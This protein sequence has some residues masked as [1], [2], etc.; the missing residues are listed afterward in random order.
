M[1]M[2]RTPLLFLALAASATSGS[3]PAAAGQAARALPTTVTA[4]FVRV[5][6]AG[7]ETKRAANRQTTAQTKKSKTAGVNSNSKSKKKGKAPA[8]KRSFHGKASWYGG[9]RFN[10][11]KTASGD[12]FSGKQ[13]SA[14]H[15]TL[16]L[17]TEVRVTN[18]ENDRSTVLE[19]NDR[20]PPKSKHV[21]DLSRAAAKKLDFVEDGSVLVRV[22]VLGNPP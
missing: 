3:A 7:P 21:I 16:P 17:G 11:R 22:D 13:L 10:G 15:P 8:A 5:V 4:D 20:L 2:I 18:L 1:S 19:I 14:A 6:A 12:V 9:K